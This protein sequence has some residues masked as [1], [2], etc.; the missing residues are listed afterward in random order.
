MDYLK[1]LFVI[2]PESTNL[3][4]ATVID[5]HGV[6]AFFDNMERGL[7]KH[8]VQTTRHLEC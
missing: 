4:Q 3:G 1:T 7:G 5:H 6:V 2:T 8:H